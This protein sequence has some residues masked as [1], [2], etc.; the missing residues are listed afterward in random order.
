MEAIIRGVVGALEDAHNVLV[1]SHIDTDGISAAAIWDILLKDIEKTHLI[2]HVEQLNPAV[3]QKIK[4]IARRFDTIVF[5]DL[6]AGHLDL[7]VRILDN[8]KK[9]IIVDHHQPVL[10]HTS[11][12]NRNIIHLNP[13]LHELDG[14]CYASASAL[15]YLVAREFYIKSIERLSIV[16]S[17][18]DRQDMRYHKLVG[19]NRVAVSDGIAE[20]SLIRE[21]GPNFPGRATKPLRLLLSK[22]KD[23][24]LPG[25]T[26]NEYGARLFFKRLGIEE[27]DK[28]GNYRTYLDLTPEEKEKLINGLIELCRDNG[29][30]ENTISELKHEYYIFPGER[31]IPELRDASEFSTLLNAC[32]RWKMTKIAM[33]L[34]EGDKNSYLGAIR[35]LHLHRRKIS[36]GLREINEKGFK[37][38]GRH[39][40]YFFSERIAPTIIGILL[41]MAIKSGIAKKNK[42]VVGASPKTRELC[43][44]SM[45]IDRSLKEKGLD[46]AT[47]VEATCRFMGCN[48]GGHSIAAGATVPKKMIPG[49]LQGLDEN[50][51][52]QL[53]MR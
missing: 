53:S 10:E 9:I 46:L 7:I 30:D 45:R 24:T 4:K 16:G 13:M 21:V 12:E 41:T 32:G 6:G 1:I 11:P 42:V 36:E 51:D 40:I 28:R 20:G 39:I 49:F 25:I 15:S 17:V 44:I 22:Y 50:I 2:L 52:F 19:L 31:D 5:C 3:L 27:I 47:A 26:D 8:S 14:T 29:Y 18:G 23:I 43:K 48:G 34:C 38:V 33:K 37:E 35:I